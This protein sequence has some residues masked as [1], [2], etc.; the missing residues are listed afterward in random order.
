MARRD[1]EQ[2]MKGGGEMLDCLKW[3]DRKLSRVCQ[4]FIMES[5][6]SLGHGEGEGDLEN[7][8]TPDD[9]LDQP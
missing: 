6:L 9:P 3:D 5:V 4:C 7:L 1:V 2:K 8:E